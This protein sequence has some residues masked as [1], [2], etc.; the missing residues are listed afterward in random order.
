MSA[1]RREFR[2]YYDYRKKA[3]RR[4]W[5]VSLFVGMLFLGVLIVNSVF[6]G[7]TRIGSTAMEPTLSVGENVL[8]SPLPYG[9]LL[10]FSE[11]KTSGFR[12]PRRGE[13]VLTRPGYHRIDSWYEHLAPIVLFF[14]LNR[15]RLDTR[16]ADWDRGLLI[17]RIVAVPGDTIKMADFV[18]YIK[19]EGAKDFISEFD[20]AQRSYTIS[21]SPLPE[22]WESRFPL[23]GNADEI[24]MGE[25]EFFVLGDNRSASSD[26]R[27]WGPVPRSK[28]KAKILAR[29]WPLG[30]AGVP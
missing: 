19:S 16:G 24:K 10:P 21:F 14:T 2:L 9:I 26:S 6:L 5:K 17:K 23:S 20:L 22:G 29:Y 7:T 27:L 4:F 11:K 15:V 13:L 18:A 25:D 30:R 1:A 28:I 12:D 3:V 8:Y